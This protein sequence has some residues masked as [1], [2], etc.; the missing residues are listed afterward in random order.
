[1]GT[2]ST[3][4]S[5]ENLAVLPL[6]PL[7][8]GEATKEISGDTECEFTIK[9]KKSAVS[10]K[11]GFF[12]SYSDNGMTMAFK[13]TN[14]EAMQEWQNSNPMKNVRIGDEIVSLNGIHGD[15]E[16]LLGVMRRSNELEI[17]LRRQLFI[18]VAVK[19]PLGIV[20]DDPDSLKVV[21]VSAG[22]IRLYN[23]SCLPNM[24]IVPGDVLLSVNGNFENLLGEIQKAAPSEDLSLVFERPKVQ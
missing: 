1:M 5:V 14:G 21:S 9:L 22:N 17:V 11:W 2:K 4:K 7:T 8:L 19:K 18:Y 16:T 23:G 10:S 20:F 13:D 6:I 3:T 12:L 15:A 24:S